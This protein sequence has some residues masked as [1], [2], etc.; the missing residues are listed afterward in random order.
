M[1]AVEFLKEWKRMCDSVTDCKNCPIGNQHIPYTKNDCALFSFYNGEASVKCVEQWSKEHPRK[2]RA[3][4]FFE[5]H[6]N[7]R[8]FYDGNPKPCAAY[9]GYCTDCSADD[10]D[11]EK[12]DC[13]SCWNQPIE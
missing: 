10:N 8:P 1:D 12:R 11:Y 9:C 13:Y 4:D 7:A 5:K 3:Q 6:P 2:T